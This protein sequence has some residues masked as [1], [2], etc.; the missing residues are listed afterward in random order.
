VTD[1][2]NGTKVT[3]GSGA[4]AS[5]RTPAFAPLYPGAEV[6]AS[7]NAAGAGAGGM[8][9]FK[10]KASPDE[11]IE[12]YKKAAASAGLGQTYSANVDN[13]Q[14][15]SASDAKTKHS[16]AVAASKDEQGTNVQLTWSNGS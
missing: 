4:G 14:S 13:T 2:K 7:V 8:V 12:Y 9:S 15:F 3:M 16:M 10:T 5:T 6:L 1:S 11:V